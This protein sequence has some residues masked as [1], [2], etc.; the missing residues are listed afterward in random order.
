MGSLLQ[1][2]CPKATFGDTSEIFNAKIHNVNFQVF[3]MII[4][5]T[6]NKL[7][8]ALVDKKLIVYMNFQVMPI[9]TIVIVSLSF[10]V[11]ATGCAAISFEVPVIIVV[12]NIPCQFSSFIVHYRKIS[13]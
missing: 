5:V 1:L 4:L 12:V 9:L 2:V 3:D 13:I 10:L 7:V 11:T 6:E 8:Q